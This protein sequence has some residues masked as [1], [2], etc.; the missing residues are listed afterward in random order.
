[1]TIAAEL[2]KMGMN[3]FYCLDNI[4]I[5]AEAAGAVV[6]SRDVTIEILQKFA[7]LLN[8][9]KSQLVPAQKMVYL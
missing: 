4:L 2:R 1:M 7:W 6:Q 8:P 9:E 5:L 3:V